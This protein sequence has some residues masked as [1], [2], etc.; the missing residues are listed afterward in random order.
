MSNIDKGKKL[1]ETYYRLIPK[2]RNPFSSFND[3]L[4]WFTTDRELKEKYPSEVNRWRYYTFLETLG[5]FSEILNNVKIYDALK[6]NAAATTKEKIPTS[7]AFNQSFVKSASQFT[8][9]DARK[10]TKDIVKE[11]TSAVGKTIGAGIGVYLIFIS[12]SIGLV[13]YAKRKK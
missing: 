13:F 12:I 1:L 11:G 3:C 2:E 5:E 8:F 10:L 4:D 6:R 7:W 9:D